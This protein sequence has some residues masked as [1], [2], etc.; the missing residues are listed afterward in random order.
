MFKFHKIS[1]QKVHTWL[2]WFDT[3]FIS[4]ILMTNAKY[5]W[6]FIKFMIIDFVYTYYG[7]IK[8]VLT[9]W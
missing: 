8:N 2:W 7:I 6:N 9:K 1:D 3:T 4:C 5:F